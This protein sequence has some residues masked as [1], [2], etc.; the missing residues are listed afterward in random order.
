MPLIYIFFVLMAE[1]LFIECKNFAA[2]GSK[3]NFRLMASCLYQPLN[4][5]LAASL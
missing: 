5:Y 2:I 1:F 3:D 4:F